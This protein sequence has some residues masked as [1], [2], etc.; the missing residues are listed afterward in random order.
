M[1]SNNLTLPVAIVA[2]AA[3]IG[4]AIIYT[5]TAPLPNK[6][7]AIET[8]SHDTVA[9]RQV[10]KA[11]HI[12]GSMDAKIVMVEYSD[13]ECPFCKKFQPVLHL[14]VNQYTEKA[15]SLAWVYR[16][17]P[18][19]QLHPRAPHEAEATECVASLG[20]EAKFWQYLDLIYT[21]T[22]GNNGLD[23]AQLPI[24]ASQVGVD[25]KKFQACLDSSK[26]AQAIANSNQEARDLGAEGTP[27]TVIIPRD[28][29]SDSTVKQLNAV[30][31][32]AAAQMEIDQSQLGYVAKDGKIVLNGALPQQIIQQ[33]ISILL[34]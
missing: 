9:I 3:L 8:P 21:T 33:L 10:T 31:A 6:T 13:T 17:F 11:D 15:N 32:V 25:T 20:G 18:I 28:A 12:L 7:A 5:R 30:F 27:F 22:P 1:N 4:G 34:S 26:F 24:L 19:P 2:A 14:L 23:P 29:V 16:H